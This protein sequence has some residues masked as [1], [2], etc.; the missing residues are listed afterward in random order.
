MAIIW[1]VQFLQPYLQMKAFDLYTDHEALRWMFCL[2]DGSNRLARWRLILMEH[3]FKVHYK[4]GSHNTVADAISRLPKY[5]ECP[6]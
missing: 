4:R 5:G 3:C 2:A 6:F 1:A